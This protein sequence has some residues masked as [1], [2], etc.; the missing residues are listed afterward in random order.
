VYAVGNGGGIARYDGTSWRRLE[1]GT[2]A[3]IRDIWGAVDPVTDTRTILSAVSNQFEPGDRKILRINPQ[4]TVDSLTW[5]ADRRPLA[6]G[7]QPNV[8]FLSLAEVF[9]L[10]VRMATGSSRLQFLSTIPITF[11]ALRTMTRW[12]VEALGSSLTGTE[13]AGVSG[14]TQGHSFGTPLLIQATGSW[15]LGKQAAVQWYFRCDVKRQAPAVSGTL[16]LLIQR[17]KQVNSNAVPS[18]A[19]LKAPLSGQVRLAGVQFNSTSQTSL[20][21]IDPFAK[22]ESILSNSTQIKRTKPTSFALHPNHPNPFNPTTTIRFDLPEG[23]N[24]SLVIYDILGRQVAELVKGQYEAGYH[25]VTWNASS[26]AGGVYLVRFVARQIE[27]G[28][29]TDASGAVKLSTTQKLVLTK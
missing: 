27:G 8:N 7:L 21:S 20:K 6:S 2:T 3:E 5:R 23:S 11:A 10:A 15:Q 12:S 22:G 4:E 14:K 29:A 9:L 26:F 18:P 16:A 1:S 19:L 28:Q 24:V 17:Y 25:S 13:L